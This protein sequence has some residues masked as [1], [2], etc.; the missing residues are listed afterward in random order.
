ME[1]HQNTWMSSVL[2]CHRVKRIICFLTGH[3]LNLGWLLS[4]VLGVLPVTYIP[5]WR[6]AW[7]GWVPGSVWQ[8]HTLGQA[9]LTCT[10]QFDCLKCP[11][12]CSHSKI[13]LI[14]S[15]SLATEEAPICLLQC[16]KFVMI[17]NL[18]TILQWSYP[19]NF[20]SQVGIIQNKEGVVTL[21]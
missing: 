10:E 2:W 15:T 9:Y 18:R 13:L 7:W 17:R 6:S 11:N 12:E 1:L 19:E 20:P 21:C 8:N 3:V 4:R 5:L 16:S 14:V